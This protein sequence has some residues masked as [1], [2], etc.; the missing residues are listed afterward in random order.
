MDTNPADN[1]PTNGELVPVVLLELPVATWS[2]ADDETKDL[3]REFALIVLN[4]ERDKID[5]PSQLLELIEELQANY[6]TIGEAQALI[7]E[8]ARAE[9]QTTIERLDY[10]MPASVQGAVQRLA[11]MLDD[12]DDYCRQGELLLSLASTAPA[13]AFRDWFFDEIY[14]QVAGGEPIPWPES[15]YATEAREAVSE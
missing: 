10:L 13:K 14:R 9:D 12:A 8:R 7:L 4:R 1:D 11:T 5:V 2:R 3:M 6:G 15:R